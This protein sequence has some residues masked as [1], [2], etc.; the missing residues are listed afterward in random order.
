MQRSSGLSLLVGI[1]IYFGERK[2]KDLAA[3][4]VPQQRTCLSAFSGEPTLYNCMLF[5]A[6]G[7]AKIYKRHK[8]NRTMDTARLLFRES[9]CYEP[10]G[11]AVK[12]LGEARYWHEKALHR[13]ALGAHMRRACCSPV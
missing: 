5:F 1:S 11:E 10:A 7:V 6:G 9:I 8:K 3:R 2:W 13:T 12:P 4:R